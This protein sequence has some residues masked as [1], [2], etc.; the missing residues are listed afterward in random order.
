MSQS[1]CE[2]M[3]VKKRECRGRRSETRTDGRKMERCNVDA[4]RSL[5]VVTH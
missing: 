4:P 5:M 3:G 2:G 1:V